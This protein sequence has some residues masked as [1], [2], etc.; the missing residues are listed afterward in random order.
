MLSSKA[1][2]P[3]SVMDP[4][5][6]VS[7]ARQTYTGAYLWV[8]DITSNIIVSASTFILCDTVATLP[9]EDS[10]DIPKSFISSLAIRIQIYIGTMT[11]IAAVKA[12]LLPPSGTQ[13]PGCFTTINLIVTIPVWVTDLCIACIFYSM[14][15]TKLYLERK[16]ERKIDTRFTLRTIY[17]I[18]LRDGTACFLLETCVDSTFN[19]DVIFRQFRIAEISTGTDVDTPVSEREVA[20]PLAP[21]EGRRPSIRRR[22]TVV[23][24]EGGNARDRAYSAHDVTGLAP[25]ITTN[26]EQDSRISLPIIT[27]DS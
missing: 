5:S 4:I 11:A 12:E 26:L 16:E 22:M 7:A 19:E 21:T 1:G 23:S 17:K 14:L 3:G 2:L 15:V 9:L 24:R 18:F 10:L 27:E 20:P 6:A 13:L 8:P 25:R